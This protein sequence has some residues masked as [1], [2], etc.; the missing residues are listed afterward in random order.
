MVAIERSGGVTVVRMGHGKAN[1][2]DIE[3][4][5]ALV[6]AFD[7]HRADDSG[8]LVLVGQ[9]S[10]FSAGVDLPR[11]LDGRRPY[12]ERF[13][14]ALIRMFE[15]ALFHPKPVVAAI[16][17]HAIAG[18]C[19]LACAAD[20]RL[21]ADGAGRIGVPELLVGVP[22]PFVALE[23]MRAAAQPH[24]LRELLWGGG[25]VVAEIA[26]RQGLVDA[27]VE[28]EALVARAVDRARSLAALPPQAFA[29]AKRQLLLPIAERLR[30]HA[31][32]ADAT[33]TDLWAADETLARV[34]AYAARVLK[35]GQRG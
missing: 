34:G 35:T 15:A 1:A 20:Q 16:N 7:A 8:A 19:V 24:A 18:G 17:G 2:L 27:V 3:L 9:G 26:L 23:I 31:A 32:Q 10:I 33:M 5:Q 11:V 25:T 4:C 14:P 12:V 13:I 28:P 6:A 30:A 21:M 22:F 29:L